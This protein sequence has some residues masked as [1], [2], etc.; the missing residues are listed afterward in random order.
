[1][2][3]RSITLKMVA[4]PIY[5]YRCE[6]CGKRS[7]ALLPSYSSPDPVCPHCGKPALGR[8][9][10]T[11][12]TARSGEDGGDDF[13]GDEMGG[14]DFGGDSDGDGGGFDDGDDL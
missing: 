13:G 5:E 8:L 1:M 3:S 2:R 14:E 6:E 11:F 10:S 9:V 4:M 12:A 7:S